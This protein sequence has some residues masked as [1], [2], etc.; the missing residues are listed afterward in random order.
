MLKLSLFSK[1]EN[2]PEGHLMMLATQR[3]FLIAGDEL[4]C[5]RSVRCLQRVQ[6]KMPSDVESVLKDADNEEEVTF[7]LL[8]SG[9]KSLSSSDLDN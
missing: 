2:G 3:T 9:E 1:R 5:S 7:I 6:A 8:W 4:G